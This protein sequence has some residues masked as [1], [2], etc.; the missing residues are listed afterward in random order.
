MFKN[1]FKTGW[2]NLMKNKLFSFIN[3]AG[4]ATGLACFMFIAVF[5]YSELSYDRYPAQSKNIYRVIVSVTGNGDVA[6]YPNVDNAI[7]PGLK[8]AFPEVKSFT[9]IVT[10]QDF[11]KY[12]DKQFKEEHLAFADSNFLQMFSIPLSEG[13]PQDPL[14]E[15]NSVV[16]SKDFAKKYFGESDALGKSVVIGL[17]NALYKITGVFDKIADNSHF[18]FDAVMSLATFGQMHLTWSNIGYYTYVL[19]NKNADPKKLEA[20]F[21]PL[22]AEHVVPEIQHDM[23]VSLAEAK[24]SVN[25]FVFSLQPLTSIHLYSH[26]KYELEPGGDIQYVYI[27]SALAI[28]ILLL[29]CV[30]F[31]NL[32]T[33]RAFKRAREVGIRKVLGSVKKQLVVQFL[34]ESVLITLMAMLIAYALLF[35]LLPYFNQLANKNIRYH[36]FLDY[37]AVAAMFGVSM[38]AGIIAG[39]YPAFFLSS[40]KTIKVLKGSATE[41]T[42]KSR[43]RS[44]LIVF[45]F[46]VSIALIIATIIVY[47]QLNYMQNKK[48]GYDKNQVLFLGDARLLG[49]NQTAFKQ[50]LLQDSRVVSASISRCIP[51]GEFM[52]GTEIYPKNKNGNGTEIHGNIYSIDYDY[53]KT[54]GIRVVEGRNFSR[55]FPT[56]SA[57]GVIINQAAVK[58]LGWSGT[59]SIGKTIV[60]SGQKEYKVIGVVAD[61]NYA[62]VKQEVAPL[63]MLLGSNYGG[64]IIKINTADVKGFLA[65]LKK[66]WNSFNPEGPISYNFLDENFAKLYASEIRTQKIFSAF[67]ILA[68]IIASLG[69]FGLSAFVIEQRTKEIGIRKVLGASVQSVL[70]LV[71]K[72]FLLL[73]GIAFLISIPVTWWAMHT[74]LQDFAYRINIS[75]WSFAIAGVIALLI[76]VLTVSFQAMKAARANPVK[77][78]RSE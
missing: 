77:S 18:H 64:L 28:F 54:L 11:V 39:I 51:G 46:F 52:G 23:G 53:L 67:A 45:Q 48:L 35:L 57:S 4:L 22:V 61:F 34:A 73:V 44:S 78:L 12:D 6:A 66:D 75:V 68:I 29:A 69:L 13:N 17:H 56:D 58:Q 16:V 76:A 1:Y 5:V 8:D 43:L 7:G 50:Q 15:P 21:R 55:D 3:I 71:S 60:R 24:K 42:Q 65:D 63:M 10:A 47:E 74:W 36:F 25:S 59:N 32:S 37:R 2:R 62:S 70:L 20:K 38:F 72:E 9:R 40:F 31:T 14:A 19:L 49:Q 26:T 27:F 30:N 41:G 33:A